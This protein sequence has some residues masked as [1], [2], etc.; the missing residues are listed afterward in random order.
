VSR[1]RKEGNVQTERVLLR[2]SF[3][4]FLLALLNGLAIPMFHNPRLALSAHLTG[5][6]NSFVLTSLALAWPL[7]RATP[8]TT[9]LIKWGFL[10]GAYMIWFTNVVG[11]AWGT[12]WLTPIAGRG[13]HA[14]KW[15]Q[16]VV[17]GA[18]MITVMI[19]IAA[20]TLVIRALRPIT[21]DEEEIEVEVTETSDIRATPTVPAR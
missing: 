18:I 11:A 15:Q 4:L 19:Y 10:F 17:A 21:D 7:L 2:A 20:S 9:R 6:M 3:F 1:T 8:R 5:L 13:F 12:N 14:A 16:L